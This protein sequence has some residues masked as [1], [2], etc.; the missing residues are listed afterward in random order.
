MAQER[1]PEKASLISIKMRAAQ[2]GPHER[3]GRHISGE[4]RIVREGDIEACL[5]EM[6]ERATTHQRGKADFMN[7]KLQLVDMDCVVYKPMLDFSEC[8]SR[9]AEEG[10][11]VAV[12]E[13]VA[14]GVTETAA[15]AGVAAILALPDSMRGAMLLDAVTGGRVDHLGNRGVRV[16]NM[17]VADPDAFRRALAAKGLQGDHV[18]E[19]LVLASKVASGEGVVAELCWSDDP[20]VRDGLRGLREERVPTHPCAQAAELRYRRPRLFRETG[21]GPGRAAGLLRG[22]GRL[23]YGRSKRL[24]YRKG[25]SRNWPA[26]MKRALRGALR[27]CSTRTP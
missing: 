12:R 27:T 5:H 20:P 2:G 15:R 16:S 13:L 21:D 7:L 22:T 6:L 26:C 19:A 9:T 3:G 17:D 23:H 24:C 10:R 4:E 25:L 11:D 14:A 8:V 18:R 1:E